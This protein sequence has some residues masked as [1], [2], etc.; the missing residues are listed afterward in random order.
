[1]HFAEQITIDAPATKVWRILAHEFDQVGRWASAIPVS[2][3]AA[4]QPA[5]AGAVVG[6]RVC[7]TVVPG[8]RAVHE[9][10]ISY[11]EAGMRFSYAA[12][13]GRPRFVA[14]AINSWSVQPISSERCTVQA[15]AVL[16]ISA[17]LGILLAPLLRYQ[18][19]RVSARSFEELKYYAEHDQP[20]PRKRAAVQ[21]AA[22]HAT[23]RP[24]SAVS[25]RSAET[26]QQP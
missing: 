25:A 22:T 19:R 1:M 14:Q 7:A 16:E 2:H 15:R 6:G 9:H 4:D 13:D 10:F 5:P 3:V 26:R 23:D 20:H 11:D 24:E 17:L 18:L 8:F 21:R 12:A